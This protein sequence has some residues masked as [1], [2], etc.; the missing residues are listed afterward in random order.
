MCAAMISSLRS[1]KGPARHRGHFRGYAARSIEPAFVPPTDLMGF[2]LAA[3]FRFGREPRSAATDA[4]PS[5]CWS[6]SEPMPFQGLE[7]TTK[8]K[9]E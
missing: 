1:V 6:T 3:D 2:R 5:R 9:T 7:E 8:S 4:Q